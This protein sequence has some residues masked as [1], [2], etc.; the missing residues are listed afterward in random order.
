MI[1]E[2]IPTCESLGDMV[3]QVLFTLTRL[4]PL[5]YCTTVLAQE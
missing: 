5:E 1:T 3:C 2:N 4:D